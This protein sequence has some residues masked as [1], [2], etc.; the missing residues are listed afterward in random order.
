MRKYV[1]SDS[2]GVPVRKFST[3]RQAFTFII[4]C[5]HYNWDIVKK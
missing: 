2:Y 4:M 3:Y 1:V 5:Q